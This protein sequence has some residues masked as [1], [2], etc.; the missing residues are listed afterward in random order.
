[1]D[2]AV[3]SGHWGSNWGYGVPPGQ[4]EFAHTLVDG[5][6]DVVHGH[7]SH[8]PRPLELYRGRPVLYGCGDLID[9]Y[10]G[11]RGHEE[12]RDELRLLYLAR[13]VPGGGAP[14]ELRM[15]PVRARRLRLEEAASEERAWLR[16]VLDRVSRGFGVRVGQEPDVLGGLLYAEP[17]TG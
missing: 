16:S 4:V 15:A 5:G 6:V 14:A 12:Y 10:E 1:G 8:H 11:I 17:A 9:D 2:G 3:G 13:L 7:S